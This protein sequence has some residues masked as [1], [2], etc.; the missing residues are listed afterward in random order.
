MNSNLNLAGIQNAGGNSNVDRYN[1][2]DSVSMLS[3]NPRNVSNGIGM[4]FVNDTY[5]SQTSM[6]LDL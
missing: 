2:R 4:N 1:R 3:D 5:R 6:K